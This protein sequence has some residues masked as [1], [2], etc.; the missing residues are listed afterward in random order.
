MDVGHFFPLAQLSENSSWRQ[1][2]TVKIVAIDNFGR[3]W[4]P[5]HEVE[6]GLD[7]KTAKERCEKHNASCGP[8]S[9][10]YY[11]VRA[12]DVKTRTL[13]DIC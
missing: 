5:E 4:M 10:S 2:F 12:D 13:D 8:Y 11:V 7:E 3:D 9:E 6:T 1:P